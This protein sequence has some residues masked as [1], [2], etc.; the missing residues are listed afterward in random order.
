M[1]SKVEL[2]ILKIPYFYRFCVLFRSM[3][4]KNIILGRYNEIQTEILGGCRIFLAKTG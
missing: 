3:K 4:I 2:Y 1:N